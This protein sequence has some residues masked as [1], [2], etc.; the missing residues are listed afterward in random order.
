MLWWP[1][2][3]HAWDMAFVSEFVCHRERA[4]GQQSN[5]HL[6][7]SITRERVVCHF[8]PPRENR[9]NILTASGKWAKNTA[10]WNFRHGN[11]DFPFSS[12]RGTWR[13]RSRSGDHSSAIFRPDWW[14]RIWISKYMWLSAHLILGIYLPCAGV[15]NVVLTL[16]LRTFTISPLF[17]LSLVL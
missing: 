1:R 17:Y 10:S 2:D 13:N 6:V 16:H 15:K 8:L 14:F 4:P 3:R 5:A 12:G 11:M 9:T 7:L